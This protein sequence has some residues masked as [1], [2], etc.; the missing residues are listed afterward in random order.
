MNEEKYKFTIVGMWIPGDIAFDE[1]LTY[2]DRFLFSY[3][4]ILDNSNG[5][6]ASNRF[7]ANIM[8][9]TSRTI[10]A[11]ISR[12]KDFDYIKQE[13]FDG[14]N[15][16][17]KVNPAYSGISKQSRKKFLSRVEIPFEENNKRLYKRNDTSSFSSEK[18][19]VNPPEEDKSTPSVFV[20]EWIQEILT[21]W[22]SL[23]LRKTPGELTKSYAT[24]VHSLKKLKRGVFFNS[25]LVSNAYKDRKFGED[26]IKQAILN[27]SLAATNYNYE[28]AKKHYK[29]KLANTYL[30]KFLYDDYL[31][32]NKSLFLIYLREPSLSSGAVD[33]KLKRDSNP[34]L[35]KAIKKAYVKY[36]LGGI[37]PEKFSNIVENKFIDSAEMLRGFFKRN[38]RKISSAF[39]TSPKSKAELLAK[40]LKGSFNGS[41]EPGNFCSDYTFDKILPVYLKEKA[42]VETDL[43]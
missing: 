9:V 37:E 42:I 23:G 15:R 6:F 24:I 25:G 14:R 32:K 39:V 8:N 20:P 40:A 18:E 41:A 12:L 26:E 4:N 34:K 16:I 28:P 1:R 36:F 43:I 13:S 7:L 30:H 11:G 35:T 17:L 27:F 19:D 38:N 31:P 22:D 33:P 2:T 10:T 21:F 29:E 3:I 5:C